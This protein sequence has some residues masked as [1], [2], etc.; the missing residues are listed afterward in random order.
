MFSHPPQGIN[1]VFSATGLLLVIVVGPKF[2]FTDARKYYLVDSR[3]V[4]RQGYLDPYKGS[5]Y[6]LQ[7]F[8]DSPSQKVKKNLQLRSLFS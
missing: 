3:Y 8:R 7:E 5:K 1:L 2:V 4:N 6:H